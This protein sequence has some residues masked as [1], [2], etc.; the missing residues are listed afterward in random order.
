MRRRAAV[1][2]VL[3]GLALAGLDLRPIA[4]ADGVVRMTWSFFGSRALSPLPSALPDFAARV[5]SLLPVSIAAAL[6]LSLALG[7]WTAAA[8]AARLGARAGVGAR[9]LLSLAWAAALDP[10]LFLFVAT[11]QVQ[12]ADR[13]LDAGDLFRA[14]GLAAACAGAMLWLSVRRSEPQRSENPALP[15]LPAAVLV[16]ILLPEAISAVCLGRHPLS[17]DEFAYLFQARLFA[18]GELAHDA[19]ALA[20]FFPSV[21]THATLGRIFAIVFPGHPALLVPGAWLGF[22]MVVPRLLAGLSVLLTWKVATRLGIRR[23]LAA[24]WLLAISPAFLGVEALAL[25]HGT[26]LPCLLLFVWAAIEAIERASISRA[27]LAGLAFSVAFAARPI[28]AVALGAPVILLLLL[29]R[30]RGAVRLAAAA[31]AASI[32][33]ALLF[34]EFD[35]RLTGDPFRTVYGTF[36][37]QPVSVYG[38]VDPG[39]AA[40]ITA[41]NLSRISIW[42]VG[43]APGLLLPAIGAAFPRGA[44]RTR[45]L[46]AM[47]ASLLA[48]YALHPFQGIPWAGPVYLSDAV[49]YLALLGAEG[50][51]A[52]GSTLGTA[53]VRAFWAACACGS[54][55]LLAGH[56]LLA[57]S[58]IE[59][60]QRPYEAARR[61]GIDRGVVFLRLDS[62]RDWRVYP[63]APP[64]PGS[65]L[66]FARDLGPR[67]G[68]LRRALGDPPA[69]VWDPGSD[70]ISP[71]D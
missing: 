5:R 31:L 52:V 59:L 57:R 65:A 70:A 8:L 26:S 42:L 44:S 34:L 11:R 50:L 49:P 66:V 56:F 47:P 60:R 23:P 45:L 27:A 18:R 7:W 67:N 54:A 35:R 6:L 39:T 15:W 9:L 4:G 53:A 62:L 71:L 48:F 32:P 16:A 28:T 38:A 29:E 69:F 61:A 63:L 3:L 46:A 40:S 43:L 25:A 58:E 36:L 2:L 41:F 12:S 68:E 33:A 30:P 1:V 20:D 24:A 14:L 17:N 55:V 13:Y 22:P 64:E 51:A 21:Q 19:G 10:H 37:D